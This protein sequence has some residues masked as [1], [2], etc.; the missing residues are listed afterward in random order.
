MIRGK[1]AVEQ[2][3]AVEV[4]GIGDTGDFAGHCL[5]FGIDH[6]A[7]VRSVG[8]C[9]GLLGQFLHADQLFVDNA[10]GAIG[11]LDQG[12]CVVGIAHA[13]VEGGDVCAHKLANGEAGRIV[14]RAVDAQ[15]AGKAL[16]GRGEVVVVP[17]KIVAYAKGH[18]IMIDIHAFLLE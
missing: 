6:Q 11:S 3:N 17:R 12:N 9:G 14:S 4:R 13:L 15:T 1:I 7:L 10:K 2:M 16:G 18:L 5:I 8:A